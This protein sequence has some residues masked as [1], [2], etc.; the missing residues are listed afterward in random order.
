[1]QWG[2]WKDL[3]LS[4]LWLPLSALVCVRIWGKT[5]VRVLWFG[6]HQSLLS[7]LSPLVCARGWELLARLLVLAALPGPSSF[8]SLVPRPQR[9]RHSSQEQSIH[10]LICWPR[11]CHF[12]RALCKRQPRIQIPYTEVYHFYPF[13]S[14]GQSFIAALPA[15]KWRRLVQ[16]T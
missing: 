10:I 7:P 4:L 8:L 14:P 3:C 16:K 1:M 12:W 15:G 6:P 2:Q 5:E 13:Q 11:T 9:P